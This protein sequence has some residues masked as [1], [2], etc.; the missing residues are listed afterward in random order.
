MIGLGSLGSVD[1]DATRLPLILPIKAR[2]PKRT[3]SFP[4]AAT[5]S[6]SLPFHS[7]PTFLLS[8]RLL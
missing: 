2:M 4:F 5:E 8:I 1:A 3:I 7:F 6:S